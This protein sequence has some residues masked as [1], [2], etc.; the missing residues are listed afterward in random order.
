MFLQKQPSVRVSIEWIYQF[1][2]F[3]RPH[4]IVYQVT[5]VIIILF[6]SPPLVVFQLFSAFVLILLITPSFLLMQDI[7][8]KKDDEKFGQKRIL[9]SDRV[10]KLFYFGWLLLL[11]LILLLNYIWS[12]VSFILLFAATIFY[13]ALKH[14]H[15]MILAYAGRYLSSIFTFSLYLFLLVGSTSSLFIDL[16][17]IVSTLDLVGNIAGDIRD[18]TKDSVAGVKTLVTTKGKEFTVRLM[19]LIVISTFVTLFILFKSTF[20]LL[21]LFCNCIPF[22]LI[23]YFPIRY[24]HGIFHI[25][26]LVNF[27]FI[28][29]FLSPIDFY[30]FLLLFC[31]IIG[32]WF[33]SYYFYLFSPNDE[34]QVFI[35]ND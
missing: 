32:S 9:F 28:T 12:L 2:H 3:I 22:F 1:L 18:K 29:Y 34:K 30:L 26:K 6:F 7:L 11:L 13:A 8:G 33:L 31:F 24:S 5:L 21:L 27:L 35:N 25:S 16:I 17:I 23:N 14:F 10:N 15:R 19:F 4:Q 20:F